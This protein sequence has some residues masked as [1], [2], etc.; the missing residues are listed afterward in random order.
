MGSLGE[1]DR[2]GDEMGRCGRGEMQGRTAGEALASKRA[3]GSEA[4]VGG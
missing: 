2:R 3:I 1:T 4:F